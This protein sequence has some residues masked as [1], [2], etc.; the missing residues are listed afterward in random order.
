MTEAQDVAGALFGQ[1]RLEDVIDGV[2][3]EPWVCDAIMVAVDDFCGD[4]QQHDDI[5]MVEIRC[6]EAV[7]VREELPAQSVAG[8]GEASIRV[9]DGPDDEVDAWEFSI[10]LSGRRLRT[11]DP[12][13]LIIS[14]VQE[15]EGLESQRH[16]LFT[17]LT[18][19]Y[20]NALDHGVLGM[21]S[22]L[23]RDAAGFAQ[24]FNERQRRLDALRKGCVRISIEVRNRPAKG[25]RAV[26]NFQDSGPG[27]DFE[28][29]SANCVASTALSGRGIA[30]VKSLC[31]SVQYTEPGNKVEV[32]YAWQ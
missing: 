32:V 29:I 14:E 3:G 4:A 20:V 5:S 9:D 19:L 31:E 26:I 23:K 25:G 15:L 11:A 13:P 28:R 12:V 7:V 21:Q 27:F 17:I 24:Y 16:A 22:D 30:L 8:P 2:A 1:D 10:A 18:E 6:C